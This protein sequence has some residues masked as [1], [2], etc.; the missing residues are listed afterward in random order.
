MG[1]NYFEMSHIKMTFTQYCKI[2]NIK[3]TSDT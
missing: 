1:D 3:Q 2:T